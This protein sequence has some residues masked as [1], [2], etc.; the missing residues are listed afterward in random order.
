VIRY[1]GY[2]SNM[3]LVSLRAKGVVPRASVRARLPGWR[4]AFDVRHWFRH[5]GGVGNIHPAPDDPG[6]EVQ[7]V[8]HTCDAE[9]LAKLDAVE[10][11][12]VGYDRVEVALE[13]D[14]GP[15]RGVAYVGMP[16][17]LDPSCRPTRRYLSVLVKGAVAAGLDVA[18]LERL[19]AN[20]LHPEADYP[21]FVHPDPAAPRF[22]RRALAALPRHTA[23]LDAVFDMSACEE[24]LTCLHALFGGK[25]TTL[26][27]VRRHDTSTGTETMQ[28]V[29][30]G[31]ISA[32]ARRYLNAYLHEY[33]REFRYAGRL[34]P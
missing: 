15:A 11:F 30:R 5:E 22:D 32:G 31:R 1:F 27:H 10:S 33:A 7:G 20:E 12:G 34:V 26:F 17:Y 13:T 16:G 6:A 28:D 23:L 4:L 24:R 14:E 18:Y 19:G 8:L 2:G 9:D 25:D 3:S 29:L 21:P